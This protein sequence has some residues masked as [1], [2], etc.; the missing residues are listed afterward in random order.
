MTLN[1]SPSENVGKY[2][3]KKYKNL[4]L[5]VLANMTSDPLNVVAHPGI[6]ARDITVAAHPNTCYSVDSPSILMVA[7]K[8]TATVT[9]KIVIF[10]LLKT[11]LRHY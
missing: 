2:K 4:H 1:T 10:C 9:L 11:L 7:H 6:P 3:T 8:R 5:A